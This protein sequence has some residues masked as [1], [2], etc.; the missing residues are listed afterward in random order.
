[1]SYT[2][3][4]IIYLDSVD[5]TNNYAMKLIDGNKAQQGMTIVAKE[6]TN[7][8]GQ[9]GKTWVDTPGESL[10]MSLI[11]GPKHI[12][13]EQFLFNA[14]VAVAVAKV[15]QNLSAGWDIAVKWPND[16]IVNDKKAGGILIENV[17]R[18]SQW[19]YSVIGLGLN[20]NQPLFPP[21]LPYATSLNIASG[22]HFDIDGV[23]E[24]V[25]SQILQDI[26]IVLAEKEQMQLF[27]SFLFK[28]D[29]M[30]PFYSD[31]DNWLAK[32]LSAQP[33]GTL[34]V[35]LENGEVTYYKH[36][37]VIWQYC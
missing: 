3:P 35:Q 15:L 31:T 34:K 11:V 10:L 7:G 37:Q 13:D 20:V 33:D 5:S 2:K 21:E 23:M 12:L 16:I 14:T 29:K 17:L 9:R 22:K 6:Q 28:K 24:S 30:Q 27:N 19:A 8:K 18:G 4:T 36:G 32:I 26:A 25:R 1:M